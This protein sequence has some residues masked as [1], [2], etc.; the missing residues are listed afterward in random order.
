MKRLLT[1]FLALAMLVSFAA[2]GKKTGSSSPSD[3]Q[4]PAPTET[5]AEPVAADAL[6][7]MDTVWALYGDDEK[8]AVFGGDMEH[9]DEEGPGAYALG[10][11]AMLD[12]DFGLPEDMA[13][14]VDDAASLRHMMNVNTFTGVAFRVTDAAEVQTVAD[15]LKEQVLQRQWMCGFPDVLVIILVDNYVVSLFGNEELVNNF[16]DK[17]LA[18]YDTATVA[19]TE[20]LNA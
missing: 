15:A 8:F 6:E 11:A 2:C 18:A 10:D 4:T 12:S 14:K 13:D 5:P 3:L 17:T 20:P 7:L 16:K 9:A 1:L 19:Y